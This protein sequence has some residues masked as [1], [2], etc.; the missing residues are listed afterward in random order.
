MNQFPVRLGNI[1][2]VGVIIVILAQQVNR[3]SAA[4]NS[5][6]RRVSD[7]YRG[8]KTVFTQLVEPAANRGSD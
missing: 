3:L 2:P 8:C 5:F 4:K 1:D 7:F 6:P